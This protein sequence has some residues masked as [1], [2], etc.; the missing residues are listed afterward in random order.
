MACVGLQ[1]HG[2]GGI[3]RVYFWNIK[4]ITGVYNAFS[5][6]PA[7]PVHLQGMV[8]RYGDKVYCFYHR[9]AAPGGSGPPY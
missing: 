4:Y 8:H 7:L 6:T 1:R 3:E 5:N 9:A 2:G